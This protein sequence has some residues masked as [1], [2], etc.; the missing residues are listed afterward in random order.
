MEVPDEV[1]ILIWM[2]LRR[3]CIL[4]DCYEYMHVA[5][6]VVLTRLAQMI[7]PKINVNTLQDI[8]SNIE[9]SHQY[10]PTAFHGQ[11]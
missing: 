2:D 5:C 8:M 1:P 3:H 6:K 9:V 7:L 11:R 4:G 10:I